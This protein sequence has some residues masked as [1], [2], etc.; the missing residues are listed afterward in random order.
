ML[1]IVCYVLSWLV[2]EAPDVCDL[3]LAAPYEVMPTVT[4]EGAQV[5]QLTI[6]QLISG[7]IGPRLMAGTSRCEVHLSY[8][9]TRPHRTVHVWSEPHVTRDTAGSTGIGSDHLRR[10]LHE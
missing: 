7:V 3:G 1:P 8:W 9:R 6:V 4:M 10:F 5:I 2:H